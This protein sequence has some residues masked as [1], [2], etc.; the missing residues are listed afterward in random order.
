M[1]LPPEVKGNRVVEEMKREKW[2]QVEKLPVRKKLWSYRW[3][4]ILPKLY[5][6]RRGPTGVLT[7][8]SLT[9]QLRVG[10]ATLK[11]RVLSVH[12]HPPEVDSV[13]GDLNR[14][15]LPRCVW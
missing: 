14:R 12:Y 10:C 5:Y 4:R 15:H 6:Q 2:G 8:A 7:V 11:I 3:P 9:I 13:R 1:V